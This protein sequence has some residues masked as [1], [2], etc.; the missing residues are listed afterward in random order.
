LGDDINSRVWQEHLELLSNFW[1]FI[2]LG[3]LEYTGSP[4]AP[5]FGIEG[6]SADSFR[7]WLRLFGETADE[8]FEEE[9]A[10]FFKQRS[11][12]IAQNFMMNLGLS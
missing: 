5:H 10:D 1:A 6:I 8:V 2:A 12:Q 7:E 11:L 3:D 4:L 9:Q